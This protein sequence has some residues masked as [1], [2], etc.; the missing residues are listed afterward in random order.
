MIVLIDG[1]NNNNLIIYS[2]LTAHFQYVHVH[3]WYI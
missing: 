2:M 3:V 1:G